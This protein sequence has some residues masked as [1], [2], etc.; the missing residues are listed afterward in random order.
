[1][2]EDAGGAI[3]GTHIDVYRPPPMDPSDLGRYMTGQRVLVIPP[4]S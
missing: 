1:V 2:A 4:G 3:K